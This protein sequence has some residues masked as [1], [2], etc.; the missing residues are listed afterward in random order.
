MNMKSAVKKKAKAI[1]RVPQNRDDAVF[2]VGRIGELRRAI[3]AHKALADEAIRLAGQ[4]FEEDTAEI[5]VELTE[6]ETGLQAWCEAN[7]FSLTNDGKVK[8]HQFA[9]GAI[10]WR[11]RPPK[12][13]IRAAEAVI[14]ACKRLGLSQFVRVKEEINKDAML[15]DADKARLI[16]GVSISSEG[17]DFVIE[18]AELE[19]SVVKA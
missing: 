14:D 18:P 1:S 11:V 7:R 13:S 12:V 4:K 3:A 5:A 15:G 19:S 17:E 2:A 9:T 10:R 8:F 16:P 6:H